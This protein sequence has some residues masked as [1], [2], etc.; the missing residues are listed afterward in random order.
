MIFQSVYQVQKVALLSEL[1]ALLG[2]FTTHKVAFVRI[3][4]DYYIHTCITIIC[5]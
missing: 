5:I 2:I 1:S 4:W 3:A